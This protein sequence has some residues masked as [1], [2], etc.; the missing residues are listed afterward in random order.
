MEIKPMRNRNVVL[1]A[2]AVLVLVV[3]LSVRGQNQ[4]VPDAAVAAVAPP[5][6]IA[7]LVLDS[8]DSRN[9]IAMRLEKKGDRDALTSS[10]ALDESALQIRRVDA[11][12][13]AGHNMDTAIALDGQKKD[14]AAAF[15][16]WNAKYNRV[17][18]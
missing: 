6:D 5:V 2:L 15:N 11:S 4:N 7:G 14:L 1:I 12:G 16:R 10:L 8:S 18:K 13:F 17:S 3:F 9:K